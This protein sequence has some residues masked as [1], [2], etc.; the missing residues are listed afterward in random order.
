ME[1]LVA[2]QYQSLKWLTYHY[3]A[4]G[5][6]VNMCKGSSSQLEGLDISREFFIKWTWINLF[7]FCI[8]WPV[9]QR[10]SSCH[11][12]S[13]TATFTSISDLQFYE[14]VIFQFVMLCMESVH[15]VLLIVQ[16]ICSFCNATHPGY[17]FILYYYLFHIGE[18]ASMPHLSDNLDALVPSGFFLF[19]RSQT[20]TENVV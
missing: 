20:P 5:V 16:V 2:K 9:C 18:A 15:F 4:S 12:T 1:W 8:R 17:L 6:S 3:T 19:V 10:I 7:L 14:Q 13:A 11:C